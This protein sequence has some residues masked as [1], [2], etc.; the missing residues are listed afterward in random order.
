L[1]G[2]GISIA[3]AD[4]GSNSLTLTLSVTS[5]VL[6][7]TAGNSGVTIS[8]SDSSSLTIS[9][10]QSAISTIL[11]GTGTGTLSYV[12]NLDNPAA[13]DRLSLTLNDNGAS[14]LGGALT[15]TAAYEFT[16]LSVND[17]PVVSLSSSTNAQALYASDVGSA[18][19]SP[20]A[21]VSDADSSY[22]SAI[23]VQITSGLTS[24]DNLFLTTAAQ[25]TLS[26]AGFTSS[27]INGTL[28]IVAIP[29]APGAT[30]K[31][32]SQED[33]AAVLAGVSFSKS[34]SVVGGVSVANRQLG[35]VALGLAHALGQRLGPSLGLN[36][37][38]LGVAVNQHIV[39]NVGPRPLARDLQAASRDVVLTQ[40]AAAIHLAPACCG[41]GR[42]NVFGAGFGFVHGLGVM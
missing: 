21:T 6:T 31:V 38:Q 29:P 22:F 26:S 28:S 14:G 20:Q 15:T 13:L 30:V 9:G 1:A 27:Y 40:N 23:Q 32:L 35:R 18:L 36:H 39:G 34:P 25:Q 2:V 5:G 11:A 24:L 3:D 10:S 4:A 12:N 17:S 19:L 42:V 41:Q 33:V 8:G 16:V 37:S 7:A